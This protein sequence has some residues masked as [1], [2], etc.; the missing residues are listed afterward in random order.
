VPWSAPG[1][2]F[3]A[4]DDTS[5]GQAC[6]GPWVRPLPGLTIDDRAEG[7]LDELMDDTPA[8]NWTWNVS[9]IGVMPPCWSG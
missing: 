6:A 2:P 7:P 9:A 3:S 4:S 5:S 1:K 8:T